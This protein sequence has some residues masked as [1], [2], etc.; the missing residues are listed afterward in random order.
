MASMARR[1]QSCGYADLINK[2]LQFPPPGNQPAVIFNEYEHYDCALRERSWGALYEMNPC[3]DYYEVN[4]QVCRQS[5]LV[6]KDI[7]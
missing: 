4:E 5:L 1:H 7:S 6:L 2:Y 3:F